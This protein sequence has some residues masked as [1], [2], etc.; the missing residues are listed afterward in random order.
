MLDIGIIVA[1]VPAENEGR[2][3]SQRGAGASLKFSPSFSSHISGYSSPP[4]DRSEHSPEKEMTEQPLIVADSKKRKQRLKTEVDLHKGEMGIGKTSSS[5]S[6][7]SSHVGDTSEKITVDGRDQCSNGGSSRKM[8]TD[9]GVAL[10]SMYSDSLEAAIL[11]LEELV[12][13]VKWVKGILE[14]GISLPNALQPSWKFLEYYACS[15]PK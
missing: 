3:D 15:T 1:A 12:N 5:D 9:G 10:N 6:F 11:D 7:S 8:G 2:T 4:P 13:K 14:H